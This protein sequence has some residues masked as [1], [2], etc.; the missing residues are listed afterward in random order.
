MSKIFRI[1]KEG[2]ETYQDWSV[3]N[4]Y[5]YD[6]TARDSI[7]DPEGATAKKEI[8]SIPSPL[9]R[10][11]LVRDAFRYVCRNK[12]SEHADTIY[13][14]M[15][16][17]TLDVGEIFFNISKLKGEVEIIRW[18]PAEEL[19]RLSSAEPYGNRCLG[20]VLSKYLASD[21]ESSN[22]SRLRNIYILNYVHGPE[23]LNIIG[24]TSPLTL[25]FSNANKLDYVSDSLVFGTHHL[26]SDDFRPLYERD[27]EYIYAWFV[28]RKSV[29]EFPMLF[30]EI[31]DYLNET[32][33]HISDRELK[34]K[35]LNA[36]GADDSLADVFIGDDRTDAVEVIGY[37]IK[38]SK[39]SA[40][41]GSDF[42]IRSN[43]VSGIKPLVLPVE[44]GNRYEDMRYTA[45]LWGNVNKAPA[46]DDRKIED[47]TLPFDGR[48]QPYL[49]AADFLEDALIEVP[50]TMNTR[51]WYAGVG[52]NAK[53][54]SGAK[55][56]Y[57]LPIK[58]LWF[59]YFSADDLKGKV[60]DFHPAFEF[61]YTPD[62]KVKAVL[63]VPIK[64]N[65]R[66]SYMEYTRV[67]SNNSENCATGK[68][69]PIIGADFTAMLMPCV[70][71][72]DASR[73]M[74][75]F[76]LIST[77]SRDKEFAVDFYN[78][79]THLT[80]IPQSLRSKS[81]ELIREQNYGLYGKLF[82]A[83]SISVNANGKA[84]KGLL[85]PNLH[86]AASN[87]QFSFAVDIG[88]SYTHIEYASSDNFTPQSFA[89]DYDAKPYSEVFV[90]QY[91][92]AGGKTV[93][94]D[95]L[96]EQPVIEKDFLPEALGYG[97]RNMAGAA[98]DFAFPSPTVLSAGRDTPWQRVVMPLGDVNIPLCFGRRRDLPHDKYYFAIK[99]GDA[100]SEIYLQKYIECV[101]M[102][103][104]SAVL[105]WGGNL[106]STR[107]VWFY[108]GSMPDV[109][110]AALER[111]WKE[112]FA[113][114][115]PAASEPRSLLESISPARY[116]YTTRADLSEMLN[117]DIGGGTTDV[118]F[119]IDRRPQWVTSF[120]FAMNDLFSDTIAEQNNRNGIIDYFAGKIRQTLIDAKLNEA[121]AVMDG[122]AN[123]RPENMATFLFSLRRS[124]MTQVLELSQRDFDHIL[125]MDS[126]FKVVF[127]VFFTAI[128]YH[129]ARI[130]RALHLNIPGH[131]AFSGNGAYVLN[132][133]FAGN[134][135]GA[136]EYITHI[137]EQATGRKAQ[138]R[139]NI[140]GMDG[141]E[142][143]KAVT[144]KGGLMSLYNNPG[145]DAAPAEYVLRTASDTF[146]PRT[147]T[148]VAINDE[149]RDGVVAAVDSFLKTA[150]GQWAAETDIQNL[151][152]VSSDSLRT[153]SDYSVRDLQIYFDKCI[154]KMAGSDRNE[155][156]RE[157]AFFYPL[158]GWLSNLSARIFSNLKMKGL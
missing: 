43:K 67:Y 96:D 121:V 142:S 44:Q 26:F 68:E 21:S 79:S 78:D 15:V 115:F 120:R 88:T 131:I 17:D 14:K 86:A 49:V 158:K 39:G 20:D 102:M 73:A 52:K 33:R 130:F 63:R 126:H 31:D 99:W 10:M 9:A 89:Y 124:A 149:Y 40:F 74:Y 50:H 113:K 59:R 6:A 54:L 157:T 80:D 153:A 25:F 5:P 145:Q 83:I 105:T 27:A 154:A 1:Y 12:D 69:Y 45:A 72:S 91:K 51:D 134:V 101:L 108:P 97:R 103:I 140:L 53:E 112:M 146:V 65:G 104:R 107:I 46:Y 106:A 77:D 13:H 156:I 151:C 111:L 90:P 93:M 66:V 152:G 48:K 117:I 141:T 35:I 100:Q 128:I 81:S 122:E 110:R 24:A 95:L 4:G 144:C 41:V 36:N 23:L 3:T 155:T 147:E 32:I 70:R 84:R 38:A 132:I 22:F 98:S 60:D 148:Y 118:A 133:I 37:R 8:T 76:S 129:V 56:S 34:N 135:T 55:Y 139:I 57:L 137:F 11:D 143:P 58:P 123:K 29:P 92:D 150:L 47:R 87:R 127:V 109:R 30:P 116:Y 82:T 28:F 75:V 16:S 94:W 138:G 42:E 119:T 64:G 125:S 85:V 136:G 114:Y 2:T 19:E 18:K 61:E 62:G 7:I 71:F